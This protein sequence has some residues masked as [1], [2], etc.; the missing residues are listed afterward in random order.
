MI[1][2]L[3]KPFS[4][5]LPMETPEHLFEANMSREKKNAKKKPSKQRINLNFK[6]V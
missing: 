2:S 5:F 1:T 3:S 4:A 6:N